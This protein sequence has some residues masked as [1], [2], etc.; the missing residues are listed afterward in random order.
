MW[1]HANQAE[2]WVWNTRGDFHYIFGSTISGSDFRLIFWRFFRGG[3]TCSLQAAALLDT[4]CSLMPFW[5]KYNFSIA[6]YVGS[7]TCRRGSYVMR[8]VYLFYFSLQTSMLHRCFLLR[9]MSMPMHYCT[10]RNLTLRR[11]KIFYGRKRTGWVW[12]LGLSDALVLSE[13]A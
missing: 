10:L 11:P 7:W 1:H 2:C 4:S 13:Q 6:T 5:H 8:D 9:P 3:G 12:N